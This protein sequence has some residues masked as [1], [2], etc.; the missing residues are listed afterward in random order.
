MSTLI[1]SYQKDFEKVIEFLKREILGLR[2]SRASSTLVENIL[3]ETYGTKMPLKKLASISIQE[4]KTILI[5]PWDKNNLKYIEKAFQNSELGLTPRVENN[6]LRLSFP[7][8]N[9]EKRKE[10]IIILH[11]KSESARIALRSVRDKIREEIF[12]REKNKEISED[13]KYRLFKEL[14]EKIG[15][16]NEEIR[17]LV[18]KKEKEIISI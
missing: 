17:D 18:E 8:L 7:P 5:E 3:V 10:L 12:K 11:Q 14:D 1:D 16:F 9:E 6:L 15:K 13:E 2:T 4:A